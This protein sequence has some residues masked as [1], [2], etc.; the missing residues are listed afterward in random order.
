M[1]AVAIFYFKPKAEKIQ[2]QYQAIRPSAPGLSAMAASWGC[3]SRSLMT[4]FQPI[5]THQ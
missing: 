3:R 2:G 4:Q 1:S 5:L